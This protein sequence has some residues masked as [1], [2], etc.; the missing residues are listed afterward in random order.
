[1]PRG[2]RKYE[3]EGREY[4]A[5]EIADL[6][7]FGIHWVYKQL[8]RVK[9]G[10]LTLRSLMTSRKDGRNFFIGADGT[11]Y[12]VQYLL[13]KIPNLTDAIA[14]Q[15]IA[16]AR[17]GEITEDKLMIPAQRRSDMYAEMYAGVNENLTPEQKKVMDE[18]TEQVFSSIDKMDEY[19][20][21]VYY[22]EEK[23]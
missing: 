11:K 20:P 23:S 1:M 18:M 17:K 6:T 22:F 4:T 16:R 8:K 5:E 3:Y 10:N 2:K 14:A 21:P 7:G 13:D 15:R 12:T 9:K 19:Y